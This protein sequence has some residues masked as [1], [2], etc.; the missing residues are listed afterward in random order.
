MSH[1]KQSKITE[2]VLLMIGIV[3]VANMHLM[4]AVLAALL[5]WGVTW[6]IGGSDMAEPHDAMYHKSKKSGGEIPWHVIK[7]GLL[8]LL[9]LWLTE[10]SIILTIVVVTVFD[11]GAT[12]VEALMDIFKGVSTEFKHHDKQQ[13][14]NA[15]HHAHHSD[16][17]HGDDH[18]D[19]HHD[20][21]GH[22]HGHGDHGD[23]DG[24]GD[25]GDDD[26]HGDH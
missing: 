3:L 26:G 20:D 18:D 4:G 11:L 22:D 24:H 14:G 13:H 12:I 21:H 16:H 8:L 7:I 2:L 9:I 23:D 6:I 1:T 5:F 25:H 15:H 10:T 17:G 19:D